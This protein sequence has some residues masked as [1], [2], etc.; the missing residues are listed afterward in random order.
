MAFSVFES[1][2]ALVLVLKL[3]T[4][5]VWPSRIV[6]DGVTVPTDVSEEVNA[7]CTPP[8]GALAGERVESCS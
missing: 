1:V 5:Y 6:T 7:I 3:A 8:W 2:C 4:A